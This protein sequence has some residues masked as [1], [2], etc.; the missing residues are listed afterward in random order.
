MLRIFARY[1]ILFFDISLYVTCPFNGRE[2]EFSSRQ[3]AYMACRGRK[4]EAEVENVI[5]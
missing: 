4:I 5:L 1:A 3:V 2:E